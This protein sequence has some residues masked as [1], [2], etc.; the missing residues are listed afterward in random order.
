M[1]PEQIPLFSSEQSVPLSEDIS[2]SPDKHYEGEEGFDLLGQPIKW[3]KIKGLDG[4]M[5]FI[6]VPREDKGETS[7]GGV[8]PDTEVSCEVCNDAPGGCQQC[9]FG[10]KSKQ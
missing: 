8:A 9:G 10:R 4:K 5:K 2:T 6:R 1:K 7:T 3:T